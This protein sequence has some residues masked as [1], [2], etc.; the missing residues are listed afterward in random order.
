MMNDVEIVAILLNDG[1]S[2]TD[3]LKLPNVSHTH[4]DETKDP[5]QRAFSGFNQETEEYIRSVKHAH[6]T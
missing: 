1:V 5:P 3:L 6:R 4:V 2:E